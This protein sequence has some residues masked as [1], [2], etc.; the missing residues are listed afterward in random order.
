MTIP[1]AAQTR[2]ARVQKSP[3]YFHEPSLCPHRQSRLRLL[4]FGIRFPSVHAGNSRRGVDLAAHD[5]TDVLAVEGAPP[6]QLPDVMSQ[7]APKP[8][9]LPLRNTLIIGGTAALFTAYGMAKWWEAGFGGGF[10]KVNEGWFGSDTQYG[11]ADKLGHMFTNYASMR[12]LIPLFEAAGNSR[13]TSV[14]LSAWTTLGIFTGIEIAD[15]YL[16]RLEVQ[17]AGCHHEPR[18]CRAWR[19]ARDPS[20]TRRRFRFSLCL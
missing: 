4:G 9:N 14:K 2:D 20:R 8:P 7:L 17:L 1:F 16:T 11:G 18:R 19:C 5:A 12:L 13:E 10:D 6:E 15:G 3:V